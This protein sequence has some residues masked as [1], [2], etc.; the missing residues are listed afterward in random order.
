MYETTRYGTDAARNLLRARHA[1]P[2]L[3]EALPTDIHDDF[4]NGFQR[5]E[6]RRF[7][8]RMYAGYQGTLAKMKT[9][10]SRVQAPSLFLWA[11]AGRH[12]R[13]S[14][15]RECAAR[16]CGMRDVRRYRARNSAGAVSCGGIA[17]RV[18][19]FAEVK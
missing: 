11:G 12:F 4:W 16:W 17:A 18:S 5:G 6:V 2:P 3:G 1:F 13:N 9:L 7:I 8:V 10:Y 19:R 15:G 14:R